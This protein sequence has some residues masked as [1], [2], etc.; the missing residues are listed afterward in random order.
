MYQVT[1]F[2]ENDRS[3]HEVVPQAGAT[4]YLFL[5]ICQINGEGKK[6]KLV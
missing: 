5:I 3:K 1:S 4:I 2:K 6:A